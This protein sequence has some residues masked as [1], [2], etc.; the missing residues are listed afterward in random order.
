MHPQYSAKSIARFWSYVDRSGDCWLWLRGKD[1][2]GY[3]KFCADRKGVKAHRFAFE[4]SKHEIPQGMKVCHSCDNPTCCNPDHLWLGSTKDNNKDKANKG[5]ANKGEDRYN[6]KLTE[7][8]V[9]EIRS[10]L[11]A[12]VLSQHSIAVRFGVSLALINNVAIG[13][14]WKHVI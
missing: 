11:L 8:S 13:K 6:A 2:D 4:V 7:C 14:A 12:G 1:K 3:G 10:L 9:R 5:R